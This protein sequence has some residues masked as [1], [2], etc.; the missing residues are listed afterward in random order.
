MVP[1][2]RRERRFDRRKDPTWTLSPCTPPGVS[3]LG[4]R[5]PPAPARPRPAARPGPALGRALRSDP[6]DLQ[7][8]GEGRSRL[9]RRPRRAGRG[10]RDDARRAHDPR[11]GDRAG[12]DRR[13]DRDARRHLPHGRPEAQPGDHV[14]AV[15]RRAAGP[16]GDP[17]GDG[18]DGP[19]QQGVADVLAHPVPGQAPGLVAARPGGHADAAPPVQQRHGLRG[20]RAAEV[21]RLGRRARRALLLRRLRGRPGLHRRRP[22]GPA[23]RDHRVRQRVRPDERPLPRQGRRT[24][25]G[26]RSAGSRSRS[27]PTARST[28]RGRSPRPSCP[29]SRR[30]TPWA[31]PSPGPTAGRSWARRSRT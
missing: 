18:V 7:P 10:R 3:P 24:R 20:R 8:P 27:T 17:R 16:Q 31:R 9:L 11:G 4:V 6:A 30:T 21:G 29:R 25:R 23:G 26:R 14:A 28:S 15:R 19:A 12:R 5:L 22:E 1:S 13:R 2:A